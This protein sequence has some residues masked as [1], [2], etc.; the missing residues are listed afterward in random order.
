[1]IVRNFNIVGVPVKPLEADPPLIVDPDAVLA[2]TVSPQFLQ[3][4]SR[5]DA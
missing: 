1:V 2:G 4:V 3:A 5:W